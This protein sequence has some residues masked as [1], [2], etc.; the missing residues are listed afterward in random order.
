M[1]VLN[2]TPDSFY[3]P[4]RVDAADAAAILERIRGMVAA[5]ASVIDLGA[6]S[7]RPGAS[8]LSVEEEWARLAPV[9]TALANSYVLSRDSSFSSGKYED[10]AISVDTTSSEIVRRVYGAIGPFIV[11]DISAGE[12]DPQMLQTV[13]E[14]GLTYIAMHKRGTPQTMDSLTDY[15]GGV[16]REIVDYFRVFARVAERV[17]IKDWILDPGLGFAKTDVQNWE[18]LQRLDVLQEFDRPILIGAADKRFTH[19]IP[20]RVLRWFGSKGAAEARL[21]CHVP[22]DPESMP[23]SFIPSGNDVAHAL[24]VSHGATILRV[25]DIPE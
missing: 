14:L 21:A 16:M 7:T 19:D 23:D 3:E 5:G 24:A 13:A 11:N 17:G 6:V 25:H 1:G 18:I 2:L 22:P 15:H 8:L 4:S 20:T 12:D 9:M 10:L